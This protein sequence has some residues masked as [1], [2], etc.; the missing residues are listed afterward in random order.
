MPLFLGSYLPQIASSWI[1]LV[2]EVTP[3]YRLGSISKKYGLSSLYIKREDI[4]A[5]VYG[6]NKVRNLEFILG[7]ALSQKKQKLTTVSPYGSNFAAALAAQSQRLG[8]RAQIHHFV[9]TVNNQLLKHFLFTQQR[10]A[11]VRLH[12]GPLY[13]SL[14]KALA[15]STFE[16][17]Q[18]DT[19]YIPA[20]GTSVQGC[21]GPLNAGLE[22]VQQVK[23]KL[24]PEPEYLFVGVG[25]CGTYAGLLVAL[26]LGGSKTKLIGI[27]CVD[28]AIANSLRISHYSNRLLRKLGLPESISAREVF[29]LEPSTL[30]YA[31]PFRKANEIVSAFWD[32]EKVRLDTTYTSKIFY[33]MLDFVD[34]FKLANK[35]ILYWHTFSAAAMDAHQFLDP[36][37][38]ENQL[39]QYAD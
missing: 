30:D 31:V 23:Q 12:S 34:K 36:C 29:L 25:T 16:G 1:S 8:M 32:L 13:W 17:A 9:P 7:E 10:G 2:P 26:R 35:K 39:A 3:V 37:V 20:G 38:T 11:D 24:I 19:Y 4:T 27:R 28:R 18:S 21:L 14:G 33:Q 22:F 6:G 15:K 5:P